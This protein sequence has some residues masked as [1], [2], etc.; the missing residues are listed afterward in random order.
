MPRARV[1]L[2]ML[3]ELFSLSIKVL[4]CI[5]CSVYKNALREH[6]GCL[7]L[8][9]PFVLHFSYNQN[10][11]WGFFSWPPAKRCRW[12]IYVQPPRS[13]CS[14]ALRSCWILWFILAFPLNGD[15]A[16]PSWCWWLLVWQWWL[17][18]PWL[19]FGAEHKGSPC[20]WGFKL[21]FAHPTPCSLST[22]LCAIRARPRR[23]PARCPAELREESWQEAPGASLLWGQAE[24]PLFG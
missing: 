1:S 20:R 5:N 12:C 7:A 24:T 14:T 19:G 17:W 23:A 13:G 9:S 2:H 11:R 16:V 15:R 8:R 21:V 22:G 6:R 10:C 18:L 4:Y 3:L